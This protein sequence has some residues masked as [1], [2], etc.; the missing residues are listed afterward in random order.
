MTARPFIHKRMTVSVSLLPTS[1]LPFSGLF[2]FRR[3]G[4]AAPCWNAGPARAQQ[5]LKTTS[6]ILSA[7]PARPVRP[8][9]PVPGPGL[10]AYTSP[11]SPVPYINYYGTPGNVSFV[12]TP[13]L[14]RTRRRVYNKRSNCQ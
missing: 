1:L 8:E 10:L 4:G 14:Y 13:L 2:S 5:G 11:L 7:V 9:G 12:T 6:R 3:G